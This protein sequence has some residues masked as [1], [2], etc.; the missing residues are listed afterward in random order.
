MGTMRPVYA[1]PRHDLPPPPVTPARDPAKHTAIPVQEA[2]LLDRYGLRHATASAAAADAFADATFA[3]AAHRPGAPEALAAALAAD[4]DLPAAHALK[5]LGA[6]ILARAELAPAARAALAEA[7]AR[8]GSAGPG[9]RALV[10]ALALGVAGRLRAAGLRLSA[11]AAEA[12]AELL[13]VKLAHAFLFMA[14]DAAAMRAVTAAALPR[15]RD[16]DPGAGFLHGLHAFALEETGDWGAAEAA[17]RRAVALEPLD[18]WGAHAV[19]H[20]FESDGR[21]AD[22]V[23][24]IEAN[25]PH[26]RG[27]NN[28]AYHMSWHLA[29]F[30]LE[31]GAVDAALA[32]Y[33][34]EVRATPTDDFRDV[35][36]AASLL[37][38]LRQEG[39]DVGGRWDELREIALRRRAD[40]TL[41]FAALHHLF[42]LVAT[43]ERAAATEMAETIAAGTGRLAD[44][45][46]PLARLIA[47]LDPGPDAPC[48]ARLADGVRRLG[49]SHAQRDVFL[50]TLARHAAAR[51]DSAGLDAVLRLRR[52]QRRD[53]RF[54]RAVAP[55]AAA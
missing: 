20:V 4:P 34:A 39:A 40:M 18:A 7:R 55:Q 17:G 26:W 50:R 13:T 16:D 49:G 32:L 44:V 33:D 5:G 41:A 14:G 29:L 22:G 45:A 54:A 47:G 12:P 53:D 31:R 52:T 11:R 2:T 35:A 46:A 30:H 21:A 51:G 25:R 28:F 38:R 19:A 23:A 48:L 24:W 10:E 8:L 37:W 27:C 6:V 9:E 42:T 3:V 43:G 36:N 1:V 15:W